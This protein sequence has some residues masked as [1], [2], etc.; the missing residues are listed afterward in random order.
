MHLVAARGSIRIDS[1]LVRPTTHMTLPARY[2]FAGAQVGGHLARLGPAH[3]GPAANLQGRRRSRPERQVRGAVPGGTDASTKGGRHVPVRAASAAE[4]VQAWRRSRPERQVRGA[5]PGGTDASAKGGRHIPVCIP[6]GADAVQARRR[7]GSER[8][9]RGAVP[10]RSDASA[11]T[12]RLVS[13]RGNARG[14]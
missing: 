9:V 12:G 1:T 10:D 3:V 14:P 6:C 11:E 7:S 13:V 5:V 2:F 4:P 8:Q